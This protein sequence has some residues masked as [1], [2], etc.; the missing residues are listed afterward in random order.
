MTTKTKPKPKQ[1]TP[2][3]QRP[4]VAVF[5]IKPPGETEPVDIEINLLGMTLAERNVAK[6]ALAQFEEPDLVEIV[7]VNAW[8]VWRRTH[9]E[10][11]LQEWVEGITFGDI[12]GAGQFDDVLDLPWVTPEGYDPEA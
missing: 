2:E 11:Q 1:T 9:P 6:K 8:V 12:I 10:S 3:P 4:G 7:A 5:R